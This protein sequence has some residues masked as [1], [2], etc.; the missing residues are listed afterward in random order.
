MEGSIGAP[1]LHNVGIR[2]VA[3]RDCHV[4]RRREGTCQDR[5][6]QHGR[7][8]PIGNGWRIQILKV[9]AVT[10][11]MFVF[12]AGEGRAPRPPPLKKLLAMSTASG[13]SPGCAFDSTWNVKSTKFEFTGGGGIRWRRIE[14]ADPVSPSVVSTEHEP[15]NDSLPTR[16]DK[17]LEWLTLSRD[18]W[19]EKC[20]ETK[21]IPKIDEP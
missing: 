5:A 20:K 11:S 16:L 12:T 2:T 9:G 10:T 4:A 8:R 19:K 21:I 15:V 6:E 3:E 1:F 14:Q 17:A 13:A 7:V 18:T